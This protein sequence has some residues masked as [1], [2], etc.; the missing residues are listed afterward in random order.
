MLGKLV[1]TLPA[2]D[3]VI[4]LEWSYTYSDVTLNAFYLEIMQ[5]P[6]AL[7]QFVT[8]HSK[9]DIDRSNRPQRVLLTG[10]GTSYHV[11]L[12]A[13][14]LLQRLDI[15]VDA[16]TGVV[17]LGLGGITTSSSELLVSELQSY[18]ANVLTATEGNTS[19]AAW[20]QSVKRKFDEMLGSLLDVIP[21]QL[22]AEAL[23]HHLGIAPG[24]RYIDNVVTRL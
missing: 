16:E 7:R 4:R 22:F 14:Y 3:F 17:V 13:S 9:L 23:A 21:T 24:F 19:H 6:D 2:H 8:Y 11:A 20:Q 1:E 10:M 18:G 15:W 5:Q 12:W